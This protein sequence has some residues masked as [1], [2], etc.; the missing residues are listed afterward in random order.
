LALAEG[1]IKKGRNGAK[2]LQALI[3]LGCG[4]DVIALTF[5]SHMWISDATLE[6]TMLFIAL[7]INKHVSRRLRGAVWKIWTHKI[8]PHRSTGFGSATQRCGT[9]CKPIFTFCGE[10]VETDIA[11]FDGSEAYFHG[12]YWG[13]M[14]SN[15]PRCGRPLH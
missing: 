3:E 11:S 6:S 14:V 15:P 13:P 8:S 2:L 12:P 5:D 10:A 1:R 7:T 9:S 4:D